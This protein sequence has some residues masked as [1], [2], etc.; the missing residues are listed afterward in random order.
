[1]PVSRGTRVVLSSSSRGTPPATAT[2]RA[3]PG[4]ER[5]PREAGRRVAIAAGTGPTPQRRRPAGGDGGR[6]CA[7]QLPLHDRDVDRRTQLGTDG[8]HLVDVVA[9][10]TVEPLRVD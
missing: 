8:E 4:G 6:E 1:M 2:L 9:Q 7:D 10:E 5:L 3:A